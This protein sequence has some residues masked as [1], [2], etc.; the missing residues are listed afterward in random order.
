MVYTVDFEGDANLRA[1]D[2]TILRNAT[3]A[4]LNT[5]S[6]LEV[7]TA[8][9][10]VD[11]TSGNV[12]VGTTNPAYTLDVHGTSNAGALTAT[13]LFRG[14]AEVPVRWNSQ[15]ETVFPQSATTAYY[16]LA[17]LGTTSDGSNGGKLR[18]SG[19]IGG[20]VETET[21][22]ID[23]FV[24]SRGGISYGGTL[25]GY[26]GD[27]TNDT[28]LVVYQE[29]NGTFAVWIKL[30]RYFTFDLTLWGGQTTDNS[31]T[32]A[33]LP[34]PTTNTSVATPTG[35]LE[36]SI[37]D[38][39]SV[40]FKADGNVGI[41]TTSPEYTLDVAG[42]SNAATY[43]QNG[44]ELYAQRRWEVDLTGQSTDNF[45]PVELKHPKYEGS[46][47]LPDMFPV[48]FKVF[49]ETLINTD[50]YNENTLVGYAR[51]GGYSD[52]QEMYDV[53][54][55]RHTKTEKR[56]EGLY[57]GTQSYLEGI[58]IYMRGG[59]RYSVLTDATEVN[60]YT[61][62]QTLNNAVFAIKDV[63]GADVSGTSANIERMVHLAGTNEGE[64][65]FMSG[66]LQLTSNLAV[67]TNDLFV[68][69]VSGRVG[70]GTASPTSSLHVTNQG[71]TFN[72]G[73]SLR[74]Q[75]N[76]VGVTAAS[77]AAGYNTGSG[78]TNNGDGSYT[79]T[80]GGG[81][82]NGAIT[83]G[84]TATANEQ[85]KIT[86]TAKTTDTS[87]P[88][89]ALENPAFNVIGGSQ[90]L[91]TTNYVTYTIYAT[92]PSNGG[93]L[94]YF[95]VNA[96]NITW[97]ALTIERADVFSG[98]YV[99]IGTTSPTSS[100]H[101]VGDLDAGN[102]LFKVDTNGTVRR[103][104]AAANCSR[105]TKY[106]G[107]ASN[108]KLIDGSYAGTSW[109]WHYIRAKFARL[110]SDVK[111]IQFSLFASDGNT[112]RVREPIII[113]QAGT[114]N[115]SCEIKVYQ[116]TSDTTYQVW[117]QIDSATSVD[118]EIETRDVDIDYTFSSVITTAIN[119]TGLTKVY[120]SSTVSSTW[121]SP[122]LRLLNGLVGIG[123]TS[124][125]APLDVVTNSEGNYIARFKNTSTAS[126]QDARVV[127]EC[128]DGGGETQLI[129]MTTD[130]S[131]TS[132]WH[133]VAGSG[134]TPNLAFQ[135][136]S[137]DYNGGTSAGYLTRKDDNTSLNFTGQHRTF[138]KD[139]PFSQA[140]DLEGLIVSA[141]NNKYIKM[142]GGIEMGSN[143]ITT[144]ESLPVVSLSTKV[145]DKKCFGVISASEDPET[146]E[147]AF[148]SFVSVSQKETG[149]TRVYINSVGEGAMWVTDING[150]LES[151]D[152]ITTS[153]V[154]GY[155]Q[156]QDSEFLANYTVA[157]IT[158]DCDFNP[159]TQPIQIIKKELSNV[160]YWVK[161]TYSNVSLEE[162]SN[163]N[164]DVRTTTTEIYYSNEDGEITTLES[165]VQST[166]TE[167]TRTIYQKIS[168]EEYK[169]EKEG[170]TLEVRQELVNVL[171]E[172]GQ[173]QWE[174][175]PTETEEA[176]KIRYLDAS[177]QQT[178]E[179][180]A[181][182]IA[183]FVGCTY[184]CG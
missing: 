167:L 143:A 132:M 8:N 75:Y 157:K 131:T 184:H 55:R 43:Y 95:R 92:L 109:K 57:E 117:L 91:T 41:G 121:N 17:T 23:A 129:L 47:D 93:G 101:V 7:G 152:Y 88:T 183:A 19:T 5:S 94:L 13:S 73:G 174:D 2:I 162:Y 30:T 177:G 35:T 89:F 179:A 48:H 10:F 80:L 127:I 180:N 128:S 61:S 1:R 108:W 96:D 170:S 148:G 58:V 36:G 50:A 124:P 106:F 175:H 79:W 68:D 150:P 72:L 37:V 26:G 56:F 98:G 172:H 182:H 18:I 49:G 62:A 115:Q 90:T 146:R 139:V 114:S 154:V 138:I 118:V 82:S 74:N 161:T 21:T 123:T 97:N 133:I 136:G 102:G 85:I 53:H 110:T 32:I 164:E 4:N 137:T 81:D 20:F 113:G 59:Y 151:G 66:N 52:H 24:A 122:N 76:S 169:T 71:G 144:N 147:D 38:A 166:Y 64:K 45:Y 70:I 69:T 51:G 22:L 67:N 141:D 134:D 65:R 135:Y 34:C 78:P 31:R 54:Y 130:E 83:L 168:T 104:I 125:S 116:K 33:V 140:G 14:V 87:S 25:T 158:M 126:D 42:T 12:G 163:L 105:L 178:D 142:S 27:P 6:N 176:Y 107:S 77:I 9:L 120:D 171:D 119:E 100:L 3:F 99:G 159:V 86:F 181:V 173:L 60:T 15:N 155:G 40:V 46:P 63:D 28:D 156:K 112:T 111:I 11:T 160:N 44:V 16:K 39:C 84:Y 153:N 145:N 29:T 165:N 103:P 149:D